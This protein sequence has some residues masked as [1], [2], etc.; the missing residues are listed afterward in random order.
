[1]SSLPPPATDDLGDLTHGL[2]VVQVLD[3]LLV[4]GPP[5]LFA[6][7]FGSNHG[8]D[9]AGSPPGLA[10]LS[11]QVFL[12]GRDVGGQGMMRLHGV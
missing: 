4:P 7:P 1:M 6:A 11:V 5:L 8:V 10:A 12:T 3:H 2:A 9:A